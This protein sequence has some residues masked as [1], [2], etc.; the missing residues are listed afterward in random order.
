MLRIYIPLRNDGDA[1]LV[2][3]TDDNGRKCKA[4]QFLKQYFRLCTKVFPYTCIAY[5]QEKTFS[6][7]CLIYSFTQIYNILKEANKLSICNRRQD[8]VYLDKSQ[9]T[10]NKKCTS[11]VYIHKGKTNQATLCSNIHIITTTVFRLAKQTSNPHC[12]P[13]NYFLLLVIRKHQS[14]QYFLNLLNTIISINITIPVQIKMYTKICL[15]SSYQNK[16]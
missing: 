16:Y 2:E 9:N 8:T 12:N 5:I 4:S 1:S 14:E 6:L 3:S 11:S 15:P 10:L 13:A 7:L